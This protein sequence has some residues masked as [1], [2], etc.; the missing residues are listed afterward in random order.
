MSLSQIFD[1][2]GPLTPLGPEGSWANRSETDAWR[3][4]LNAQI[5]EAAG[6]LDQE[7]PHLR[8]YTLVGQRQILRRMSPLTSVPPLPF[9]VVPGGPPVDLAADETRVLRNEIHLQPHF[10][11]LYVRQLNRLVNDSVFRAFAAPHASQFI[12]SDLGAVSLTNIACEFL[13]DSSRAFWSAPARAL[14]LDAL[15]AQTQ[16]LRDCLA[17]L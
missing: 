7:F 8:T 16:R 10:A 13:S 3:H 1:A 9:V 4:E 12:P 15:P 14:A 2:P 11:D 17:V 5:A 6:Q